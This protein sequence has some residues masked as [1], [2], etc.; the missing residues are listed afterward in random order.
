MEDI[1]AVVGSTKFAVPNGLHVARLVILEEVSTNRPDAI[2]SGG[3][4]GV[5]TLAEEIAHAHNIRFIGRP[6]KVRRWE[7]AGGFRERNLQIANTC[8]R[9]L[10]VVCAYSKTYGSGWTVDRAAEMGKP[11]RR[12]VIADTCTD[13]GWV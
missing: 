2:V 13:S 3:A 5:D 6:A 1:L 12:V 10:R 11:V 8:T 9:A 4:E 7:G